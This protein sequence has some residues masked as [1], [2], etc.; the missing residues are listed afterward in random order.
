MNSSKDTE[1]ID[2]SVTA[3]LIC[4][5]E[6]LYNIC[7]DILIFLDYENIGLDTIF[8]KFAS[9]EPQ[10]LKKMAFFIMAALI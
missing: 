9:A 7:I 6:I 4:T 10:M 5:L 8:V 2:I 1:Q 3:A